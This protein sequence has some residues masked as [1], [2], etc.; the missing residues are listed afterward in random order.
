MSKMILAADY[1]KQCGLCV[2]NCPRGALRFGEDFNKG[3]YK[4]VVVDEEKCVKCGICYTVCP[5]IVF[6]FVEEGGEV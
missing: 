3:G 6:Q 5:D 4:A 2:A 1:C